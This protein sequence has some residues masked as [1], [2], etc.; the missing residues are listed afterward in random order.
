M[1][2]ARAIFTVLFAACTIA[3]RPAAKIKWVEVDLS[4][5]LNGQAEV[6]TKS[7]GR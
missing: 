6:D 5:R 4:P 1:R 3:A 7:A 2:I